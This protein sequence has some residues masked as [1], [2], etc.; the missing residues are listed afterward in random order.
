MDPQDKASPESKSAITRWLA[1]AP[2]STFIVFAIVSSFSAYFCMYAFRKPFSAATYDGLGLELFG[3]DVELKTAFVVSQIIGYALSKIIGIKLCSEVTRRKRTLML[4]VMIALAELALLLFA[5]L[6]QN[7]KIVAIFLNGLPLGMV[8]GLVVW[9]LEGRRRSEL[10][11]AGLSGSFIVASGVVKDIGIWLMTE[12]AVDQFWMPVV[13]GLIFLP[14]FFVSVWLL[15]QLP[16][17]T[18]E[19]VRSRVVREP[20]GRA[21]RWAFM[22]KFL[23]GLVMLLIAYFF[24]TA[25]RDFRDNF[26]KEIF[27]QL[28]YGE[29]EKAI[30]TRSELWVAF[31]VLGALALLNVVKSN[32]AGLVAAFGVM[33]TGAAMMGVG[34]LLLDAGQIDGLT[35][36]IL[37]GLGSYLAYVPYGSVLF[38]RL[39]ASTRTVGTAVF[40]IYVADSVGYCGAITVIM[41]K[42]LVAADIS[43]LEFFRYM[44]YFMSILGVVMLVASCAYLLLC[45]EHLPPETAEES[46]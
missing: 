29:D 20:M 13:T 45:H 10:L 23:P 6:P 19:D 46:E 31:G 5:V 14:P 3:R 32:R 25:Y 42:D 4:V 8:W 15:N 22:K 44:T 18:Q 39:I 28:G 17:P 43:R 24:L 12:H 27:E 16:E 30:F 40:V 41:T 26:G 36:M 1:S 7:W 34:T 38:D 9:Y 21:D 2:T 35:W 37:C 11:L 33:T